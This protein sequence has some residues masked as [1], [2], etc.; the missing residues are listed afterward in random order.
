MW[1][2]EGFIHPLD[3]S[4]SYDN[5]LENL[6]DGY[7]QEL[8]TRNLIEPTE[9]SALTRYT[10]TMHDVVQSFAEFMSKEESL[11]VQDTQDEGGSRIG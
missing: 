11:V 10:C 3:R 1:I 8:I 4:S 9:E 7:Y 5:Q 2:S 6:A